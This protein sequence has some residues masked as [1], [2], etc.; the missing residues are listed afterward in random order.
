VVIVGLGLDGLG[1]APVQTVPG[2]DRFLGK[3]IGPVVDAFLAV[4]G[5]GSVAIFVGKVDIGPGRHIA[6]RQIVGEELDIACA[7]PTPCLSMAA[8]SARA[9]RQARAMAG[10]EVITSDGLGFARAPRSAPGG[11]HREAG[12][13][14]RVLHGRHGHDRAGPAREHAPPERAGGAGRAGRQ[15]VPLRQPRPV[16]RAVLR[17]AVTTP[18]GR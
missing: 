6:M 2:A 7:A 8:P 5:D 16:I 15:P 14:V 18:G 17:A 10:R 1:R 9:P 12:G 4:H 11:V 3:P 13:G